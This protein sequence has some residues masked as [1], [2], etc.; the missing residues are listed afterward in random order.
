MQTYRTEITISNDGTLFINDLPFQAGD[1]VEVFVR[2]RE[3]EPNITSPY[4]LR[5]TSD[6]YLK[7][8]ES[9]A[10]DVWDVLS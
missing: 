10:E 8:F 9:V 3:L 5:N 7:P 4:P 6:Q 2:N 1:K